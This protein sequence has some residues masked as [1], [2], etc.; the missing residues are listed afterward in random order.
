MLWHKS[1]VLISGS[2]GSA[3][4]A[5]RPFQPLRN[6]ARRSGI[7]IPRQPRSAGNSME[8]NPDKSTPGQK[9]MT[10]GGT[11]SRRRYRG[12]R[13]CRWSSTRGGGV[14][15]LASS[16]AR[17]GRP[18]QAKCRAKENQRRVFT[19]ITATKRWK[20]RRYGGRDNL[21]PALSWANRPSMAGSEASEELQRAWVAT[22]TAIQD[23]LGAVKTA[24]VTWST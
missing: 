22:I 2:T 10:T 6:M 19:Y 24:T 11:R 23:V 21:F 3:L 4:G 14:G 20:K 18:F 15:R 8:P 13:S 16:T 5:V 17:L 9:G 7:M 1:V 12:G